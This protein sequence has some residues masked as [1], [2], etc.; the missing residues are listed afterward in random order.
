[1]YGIIN[2]KNQ[3]CDPNVDS[4]AN[5]IPD[6]IENILILRD[7]PSSQISKPD[8]IFHKKNWSNCIFPIDLSHYIFLET[9][10]TN[11][12]FSHSNLIGTMFNKS[13]LTDATFSNSNL[14]GV[15]FFNSDLFNVNFDNVSFSSNSWQQP[16]LLF[17]YIEEH[18]PDGVT[19][20]T[21]Y[22]CFFAPCIYHAMP[23]T[24]LSQLY[25]ITFNGKFPLNVKYVDTN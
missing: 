18:M 7:V 8:M 14:H 2:V 22:T 19:I 3:T 10:L 20:G 17:T 1:M 13:I 25:E 12:D 15:S 6:E 23:A 4:N 24:G 5:N 21:T 11:A 16:F 9:D